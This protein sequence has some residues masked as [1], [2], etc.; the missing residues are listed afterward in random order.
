MSLK[1][2]TVV[3]A[4]AIGTHRINKMKLKQFFFQTLLFCA[5]CVYIDCKCISMNRNCFIL[6]T[7]LM[8]FPAKRGNRDRCA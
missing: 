5:Q 4:T 6:G 8:D 3:V 1:K 2:N 7:T